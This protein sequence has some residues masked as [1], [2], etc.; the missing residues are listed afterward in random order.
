MPITVS[1]EAIICLIL[2]G[3]FLKITKLNASLAHNIGIEEPIDRTFFV[4]L[5]ICY[6][7]NTIIVNKRISI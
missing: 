4:S 5:I 6:D 7:N 2:S 3:I 1:D